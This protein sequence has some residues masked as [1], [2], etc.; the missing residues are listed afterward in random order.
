MA[1][2]TINRILTPVDVINNLTS[3]AIDKPLSAA[4]GKALND[5][6][7]KK[8]SYTT[9]FDVSVAS[10]GCHF[11]CDRIGKTIFIDIVINFTSAVAINTQIAHIDGISNILE[12][13]TSTIGS[14]GTGARFLLQSNGILKVER[15][16]P[17]NEWFSLSFIA[18]YN[19]D[20]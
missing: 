4:Q 8:N 16:L 9:E 19:N 3:T 10:S 11:Y 6:T 5:K 7:L 14:N 1:N 20:V 12:T 13:H 2:G 18:M 17:A 15:A